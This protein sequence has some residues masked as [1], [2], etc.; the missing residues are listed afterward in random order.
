MV[1]TPP[2]APATIGNFTL[3]PTLPLP[4]PQTV[5]IPTPHLVP[6]KEE[7][8][9]ALYKIMRLTSYKL[10]MEE[11]DKNSPN[12]KRTLYNEWR[13]ALTRELAPAGL[14]N[15]LLDDND[16]K[17]HLTHYVVLGRIHEALIME[18]DLLDK[19]PHKI[20][21]RLQARY[22]PA[23]ESLANALNREWELLQPEPHTR[24]SEY[25]DQ[26]NMHL[27]R[28]RTI[29]HTKTDA[30]VISKMTSGWSG[31]WEIFSTHTL[32]YFQLAQRPPTLDEIVAAFDAHE[33]KLDS[34]LNTFI[35][36]TSR[37]IALKAQASTNTR[38]VCD[39]CLDKTH[40]RRNHNHH[41]NACWVNPQSPAYCPNFGQYQKPTHPSQQ[42]SAHV[43]QAPY[44][45][46]P[47]YV[48][49]WAM[50]PPF[51]MYAP[52]ANYG[53]SLIRAEHN[54]YYMHGPMYR[55][56]GIAQNTNAADYTNKDATNDASGH[57][58]AHVGNGSSQGVRIVDSGCTHPMTPNTGLFKQ[59]SLRPCHITISLG[60]D[61]T[62]TST[63]KGT[64]DLPILVDGK[65]K[66]WTLHN[67]LLI[68]GLAYDLL[69]VSRL[70][71]E[72]KDI[73]FRDNGCDIVDKQTGKLVVQAQ[74]EAGHYLLNEPMPAAILT[75][76]A[77]LSRQGRPNASCVHAFH[78]RFGHVGVKR[79][80]EMVC[81]S[82]AHSVDLQLSDFD[83]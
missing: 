14:S 71:D 63:H 42:G 18:L 69:S 8:Y 80:R 29:G 11:A 83:K 19:S 12:R 7:D 70:T 56:A 5:P 38:P 17:V 26:V 33:L 66:I 23:A 41:P 77:L 1:N 24:W 46:P 39:Y 48:S 68:P 31:Q 32:N 58:N 54:P 64:I 15:G 79:M 62:I 20:L 61:L 13:F 67:V 44:G 73:L 22:A 82:M 34:A 74:K 35:Q 21:T 53:M 36:E 4:Q 72:G 40:C 47:V 10:V 60:D 81:Y 9:D 27:R 3:Q 30:D 43:A 78:K 59:C 45:A 49:P 16:P 6:L 37:N 76:A 65:E 51:S 2:L 75:A 52:P 57:G 55:L 50:F 28:L 25:R